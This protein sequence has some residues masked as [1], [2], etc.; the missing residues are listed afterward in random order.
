MAAGGAARRR[1]E[2]A[3]GIRFLNYRFSVASFF[4]PIMG[5]RDGRLNF[6][7]ADCGGCGTSEVGEGY[8]DTDCD[9]A[10]HERENG[11]AAE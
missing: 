3:A 7:C 8:V 10:Q 4:R 2:G 1:R 9:A 6:A 5:R 11:S